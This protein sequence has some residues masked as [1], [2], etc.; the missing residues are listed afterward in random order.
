MSELIST[1]LKAGI[2]LALVAVVVLGSIAPSIDSK[3]SDI[4]EDIE[5]TS[6]STITN[7]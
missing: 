3:G 1:I 6:T 7:N 2:V 5:G 4:S